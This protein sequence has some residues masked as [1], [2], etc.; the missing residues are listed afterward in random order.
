MTDSQ[1]EIQY[2]GTYV[3]DDG[4]SV[5]NPLVIATGA[6]DDFISSVTVSVVFSSPTYSYV[7]NI[8]SFTYSVTWGNLQVED[9]I[10][11][12]MDAHKL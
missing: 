6:S 1:I 9:F 11:S 10:N 2:T 7:R 3:L 4:N 5:V 12:Y 8:G